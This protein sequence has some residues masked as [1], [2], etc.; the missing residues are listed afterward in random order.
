MHSHEFGQLRETPKSPG[1]EPDVWHGNVCGLVALEHIPVW[2]PQVRHWRYA[3][4]MHDR[5]SPQVTRERSTQMAPEIRHFAKVVLRLK[6]AAE[7]IALRDKLAGRVIPLWEQ[8]VERLLNVLET[9]IL[10]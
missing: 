7:R 4:R 2:L 3:G 8:R 9:A 6:P 1:S 10:D 5:R